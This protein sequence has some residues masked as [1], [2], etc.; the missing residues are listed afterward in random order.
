[1]DRLPEFDRIVV[2]VDPPISGHNRSDECGIVVVGLVA[3]G[4]MADWT[5]YVIEDA[6]VSAASPLE[7]ATAAV[8]AMQRHGADRI[9]AEVNQ[10]GEMVETILRQVDQTVPYRPLHASKGKGL[11]AEP[12]AALYEQGRIKHSRG[13]G[14]L[15]DQMGL[16]TVQGYE[17]QGSPDRADA[18]VWAVYELMLSKALRP[19]FPRLRA[20]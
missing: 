5:C 20:L 11:R 15:E 6:S 4:P 14:E 3:E 1:V 7:W 17:G 8:K 18:L 12:V 16:M 10:G 2:A 19:G 9:V 13:L